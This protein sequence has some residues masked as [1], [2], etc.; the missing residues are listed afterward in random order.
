MIRVVFEPFLYVRASLAHLNVR[1]V[2]KIP[3]LPH[4][5]EG[6]E[7]QAVAHLAQGHKAGCEPTRCG[8]S[9]PQGLALGWSTGK[10]GQPPGSLL[11]W[12]LTVRRRCAWLGIR[13]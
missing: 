11:Y 4:L 5:T 10:A 7:T 13:K 12:A 3:S 8:E 6:T 1:V 2:W 9:I